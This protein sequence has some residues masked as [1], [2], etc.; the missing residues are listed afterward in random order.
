[1]NAQELAHRVTGGIEVTLYWYATENRT[2]IEVSQPA[3]EE[4]IAFSV[5]RA[6]ALDAFYHPFAYLP[7]GLSGG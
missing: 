4:R 7:S 5:P 1:M 3:P 6:R 2:S